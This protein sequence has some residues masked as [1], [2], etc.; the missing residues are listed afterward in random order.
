MSDNFNLYEV[1]L[2]GVTVV[3]CIVFGVYIFLEFQRLILEARNDKQRKNIKNKRISVLLNHLGLE[4][5]KELFVE[6]VNYSSN[7][8]TVYLDGADVYKVEFAPKSERLEKVIRVTNRGE[9][10]S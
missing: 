9:G 7:S 5:E 3:F 6:P 10:K 2:I 8:F 4:T 1:F